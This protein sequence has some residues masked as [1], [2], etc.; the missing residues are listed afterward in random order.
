V[1]GRTDLLE[2]AAILEGARAAVTADSGPMHVAAAVGA[3]LVVLF[4]P[5]DPRRFGP[6]GRPG[7]VTILQGTRYP[8]DPARWHADIRVDEVVAATLE[9]ARS[10]RATAMD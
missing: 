7:Q 3:P 6:R 1:A 5:G 4:G 2:L 8:H 9:R 10:P